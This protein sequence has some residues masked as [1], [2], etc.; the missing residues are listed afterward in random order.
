LVEPGSGPVVTL[1]GASPRGF[2]IFI[3]ALLSREAAA[4]AFLAPFSRSL[5][6]A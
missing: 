4:G 2:W 5:A 1:C 6:L 3:V